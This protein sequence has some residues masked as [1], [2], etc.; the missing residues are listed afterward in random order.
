M[1]SSAMD[2]D[3]VL[4]VNNEGQVIIWEKHGGMNQRF[5]VRSRGGKII[6]MAFDGS[7][8]E[9]AGGTDESGAQIRVG[10]PNN[11]QNEFWELEPQGGQ[12]GAYYLKTFCGKAMDV[13]GG[14]SDSGSK[15]IQWDFNGNANQIWFLE[16]A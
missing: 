4:D 8:V 10:Y 13:E 7:T 5:K 16:P 11:I 15:V 12:E 6:L 9:V 14:S 2:R 1:I 3:K